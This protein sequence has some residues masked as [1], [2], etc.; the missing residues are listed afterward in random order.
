MRNNRKK[1]VIFA[2]LTATTAAVSTAVLFIKRHARKGRNIIFSLIAAVMLC[3]MMGATVTAYAY[4]EPDADREVDLDE[5][6]TSVVTPDPT[7]E[8]TPTPEP[9]PLTPDGNLTL[10]DDISGE[11]AED[12]Q[13]IT[14]I[15]KNGNYFY[16][17]IDRAGDKENVYFLNLVDE[18]DLLALIED[19]DTT[20]ATVTPTVETSEPT[21]TPEPTPEPEA[22]SKTGS[23]LIVI[24][25]LAALGGGAAYYIKV[26][27]PKQSAKGDTQLSELDEFDF[28][29]DEDE[30]S[31]ESTGEQDGADY[32]GGG[33]IPDFT[34]LEPPTPDSP[35]DGY[36]DNF[37]FGIDESEGKE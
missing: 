30:L 31:G 3:G 16:L 13:F 9:V 21:T 4:T 2:V 25:L 26:I 7:P 35:L 10:V 17:I 1:R 5:I 23:I 15:T 12:K 28:D 34:D 18:A 6:L 27:R 14:V 36:G 29:E 37:T 20:P 22:E 24:L 19:T 32:D 11:Q 33:E 8:P